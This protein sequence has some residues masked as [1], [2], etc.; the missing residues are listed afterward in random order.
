MPSKELTMARAVRCVRGGV[1]ALCLEIV[2][3]GT[4]LLMADV[5]GSSPLTSIVVCFS[6]LLSSYQLVGGGLLSSLPIYCTF[7]AYTRMSASFFNIIT[8][9][10]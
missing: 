3:R 7:I 4:R 8:S 9:K 1:Y 2:A 10:E 6:L 5:S